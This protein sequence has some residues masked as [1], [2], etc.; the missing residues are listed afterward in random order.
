M[1]LPSVKIKLAFSLKAYK[2]QPNNTKGLMNMVKLTLF[3]QVKREDAFNSISLLNMEMIISLLLVSMLWFFW[4]DGH[5]TLGQLNIVTIKILNPEQSHYGLPHHH[6]A[7]PQAVWTQV[8]LCSS[9]LFKF[10]SV[11]IDLLK[12]SFYDPIDPKQKFE[13][14]DAQLIA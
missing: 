9:L 5:L 1:I 4:G 12:S 3:L 6:M 11:K 2:Y 14:I 7:L 13:L 10:L 8:S